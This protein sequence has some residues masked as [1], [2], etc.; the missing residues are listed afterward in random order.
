MSVELK[1]C[2]KCG[3]QMPK[4]STKRICPAC[5]TPWPL[6]GPCARC[7]T[8]SDSLMSS[9]HYCH[10]CHSASNLEIYHKMIED[11][12]KQYKEWKD[13]VP[14]EYTLLTEEEWLSACSYFNK[15]PICNAGTI[16]TKMYFI[17]FR[18]GGKYTAWNILPVCEK[19][20]VGIRINKCQ[21]FEHIMRVSSS[22]VAG[23]KIIKEVTTFLEGRIN[24]QEGKGNKT[25]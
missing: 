8:Y 10:E 6:A 13:K 15:C 16:D 25:T 7:G 14:K 18:D 23:R 19:C 21:P 9:D 24:E 22:R 2:V 3:Y 1:T 11:T 5:K 4:M 20:A 17:P 12:F